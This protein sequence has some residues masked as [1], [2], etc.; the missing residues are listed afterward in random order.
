MFGVN[1]TPRIPT[2]NSP[3]ATKPGA[4]GREVELQTTGSHVQWRYKGFT[5]WNDLIALVD[6]KGDKGDTGKPG[7]NGTDG[8]DGVQGIPGANG[9]AGP[10][11]MPGADGKPGL[12]GLDGKDGK[13]GR[14]VELRVSA[15]YIQWRYVGEK[16][17]ENLIALDELRGPQ[18]KPGP[19]GDKGEKGE[20]GINGFAG[21]QGA[22]GPQGFTGPAG[23]AGTGVPAAGAAGQVL[24][25]IDG[26]DYN[27]EWVDPTA[28][29]GVSEELAIAYAIAL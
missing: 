28:G 1:P 12:D 4:D 11:G 7:V 20:R 2:N 29:G 6:L 25:K 16:L 10:K 14:E 21:T 9:V 17:W 5:K 23:P 18:G 8:K 26:T 22:R 3:G 19:K 15:G 13:D 27:T 24:A